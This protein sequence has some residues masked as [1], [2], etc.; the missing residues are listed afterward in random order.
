MS[1]RNIVHW[2][3]SLAVSREAR[4]GGGLGPDG[5]VHGAVHLQVPEGGA[6]GPPLPPHGTP[7]Q[8]A[9]E[10]RVHRRD[11]VRV[12]QRTRQA[13]FKIAKSTV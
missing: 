2:P 6:R 8:H 12:L 5:E 13:Y 11:H 9:R 10:Q 3:I 1:D 7:P 4:A